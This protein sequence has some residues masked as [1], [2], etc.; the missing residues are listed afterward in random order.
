MCSSTYDPGSAA[1]RTRHR[2]PW[3]PV[4]SSRNTATP[5]RPLRLPDRLHGGEPR[6]HAQCAVE[7]AALG[8]RVEM[9]ARPDLGQLR[10]AAAQASHDVAPPVHLDLEAGLLEPPNRQRTGLVFLR[11][12]A[13]P[14][15]ADA[16]SD[17]ENVVE[18]PF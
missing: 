6:D 15:G 8:H 3:Q 5:E 4:S 14:V 13:D 2:L 18:P 11:R 17:V 16:V 7:A 12:P 1:F 10:R 9:R